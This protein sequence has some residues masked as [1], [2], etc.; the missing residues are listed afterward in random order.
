M[1]EPYVIKK[2]ST[3]GDRR[4]PNCKE[5]TVPEGKVFVLGDNRI[6][7]Y[8]E[9][10][11]L[12]ET[13]LPSISDIVSYLPVEYQDFLAKWQ[14]GNLD[15][16]KVNL[17]TEQGILEILNMVRNNKNKYPVR[18]NENLK[19]AAEIISRDVIKNSDYEY[20]P[21]KVARALAKANYLKRAHYYILQGIYDRESYEL[22]F[23]YNPDFKNWFTESDSILEMGISTYEEEIDGCR[24]AVT[25]FLWNEKNE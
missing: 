9:D 8:E 7:F 15:V 12:P 2:A 1:Q 13:D 10:V 25:L 22:M 16:Q 6:L 5:I 20:S 17:G 24:S 11:R 23:N 14:K 19:K 4:I 21:D 3:Y 18:S